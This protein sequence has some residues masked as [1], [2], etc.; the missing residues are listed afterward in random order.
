MVG[1]HQNTVAITFGLTLTIFCLLI[2]VA[3]AVTPDKSS[4]K[5]DSV[6]EKL[7]KRLID[8]EADPLTQSEENDTKNQKPDKQSDK[9]PT[10]K[11]APK[12]AAKVS[13]QTPAAKNIKEIQSKINEYDNRIEILE[14][15]LRRLRSSIYDASVTDNQVM[16]EVK[17]N[18]SSNFIIKTLTAR[19]DGSTLYDQSEGSGLWMPSRS[20][21]LFFGPLK[22]GDHQLEILATIAPAASSGVESPTWKNKSLQQSL[23]FAIPDGKSRKH[24]SIEITDQGNDGSKPVA[25]LT[26][27]DLK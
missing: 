11:Y 25:K 1:K 18:D 12:A 24:L 21:P 27:G 16:L 20:I 13:A 9:N 19:L 22:P 3:I 6:L 10:Q 23:S 17:S 4:E 26:E 7:E 15:D 14:S 2:P 8:R 5:L